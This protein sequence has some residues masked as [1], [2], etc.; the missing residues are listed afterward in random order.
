MR[1]RLIHFLAIILVLS[2]LPFSAFAS[3]TQA[4]F[5]NWTLTNMS[6]SSTDEGEIVSVNADAAS[7]K[8]AYNGSTSAN[9]V[10][11]SFM[12][13][14]RRDTGIP[15]GNVGFEYGN[16]FFEYNAY[17]GY[18]R[19]R[20]LNDANTDLY[21]ES[22]VLNDGWNTFYVSFASGKLIMRINDTVIADA[23]RAIP[24]ST[25]YQISG[26]NT[27]NV[28]IRDL[29]LRTNASQEDAGFES[30]KLTDIT[31]Q[32][33][34]EVTVAVTNAGAAS[35]KMTYDGE[36][37]A[38][39]VSFS[40]QYDGLKN[41]TIPDGNLGFE[42]GSYFFE[43]YAYGGYGR[44][45]D[46]NDAN[47]DLYRANVTLNEGWNSFYVSVADGKMLMKINDTV[48]ADTAAALPDTSFYQI[49]GYN[50][51]V[52]IRDLTLTGTLVEKVE[53][54]EQWDTSGWTLS[55]EDGFGVA[56][57]TTNT[58]RMK[59][60]GATTAKEI[61][62]DFRIDNGA[63]DPR[64][65]YVG[66]WFYSDSENRLFF[67]YNTAF[68]KAR[69]RLLGSNAHVLFD[70]EAGSLPL[71]NGWHTFKAEFD[72]NKAVMKIDGAVV[73]SSDNTYGETFEATT[74][75]IATYW[76]LASIRSIKLE[77]V[78]IDDTVERALDFE[79]ETESAAE[80]FTAENG[81]VSLENGALIYRLTG[82]S[83]ALM[84]PGIR[85]AD[86]D[87]YCAKLPQ[88]NSVFFHIKNSTSATQ[89]RVYFKTNLAPFY[90]ENRSVVVEI[91][92][93]SGYASYLANFSRAGSFS[94]YIRGLKFEP[95][96]AS[97]GTIE[98]ESIR[99]E[100]ED[101]YYDYAGELT[102]CT[103]AGDQITI[104]GVVE[105][106]FR[107]KTVSLYE[108]T[109][110]NYDSSLI[111]SEKI[112]EVTPDG[113]G[114][115][116]TLPLVH[117]GTS[118]L[119]SLFILAVDGVR[120]TNRFPVEYEGE[121]PYAFELPTL[122]VDVTDYGAKGDG[123]TDDT[124]AIQAAID[125]VTARG[126]GVV[127]L[128]GDL[129]TELGKRY[130]AT[131]IQLKSN[132]ELRIEEGAMV[133]Q[134]PYLEH[135]NYPDKGYGTKPMYG[136][137][138]DL[139]GVNWA[140]AGLTINYP[141]IW[142]YEEEN[143]KISGGG[144]VRSVDTGSQNVS[145]TRSETS[146][147]P[148][149]AGDGD[150]WTGCSG[151]LHV[152]PIGM[153]GCKN[154][155]VTNIHVRRS[156]CYQVKFRAC[157]NIYLGNLTL[158]DSACASGDGLSFSGPATHVMID[159]C[160]L[161]S[162][163]DGIVL[164]TTYNDLRGLAW[165]HS[166]PDI[167]N[168]IDDVTVRYSAVTSGHG[169]TFIP[170]GTD[171]LDISWMEIKNIVAHDCVFGNDLCSVGGWYDNPYLNNDLGNNDHTTVKNVRLYNNTYRGAAS[172]WPLQITNI[173][174]DCG[175]YSPSNF[176]HGDFEREYH[177]SFKPNSV[178]GLSNWSHESDNESSVIST[179]SLGENHFGYIY[180]NGKLYQGLH[181]AAGSYA[182]TAEAALFG[183]N[184]T[185]FVADAVSGAVLEEF[186]LAVKDYFDRYTM[187]FSLEQAT[188]VYVG[189]SLTGG[190]NALVYLDNAVINPAG[191]KLDD[192]TPDTTP[193]EPIYSLEEETPVNKALLN[194]AIA[195]AEALAEEDYTAESW[196]ALESALQRAKAVSADE[197][198]SQTQVDEAL[199]ALNAAMA[200]LEEKPVEPVDPIDPVEPIVPGDPIVPARPGAPVSNPGASG[201][202]F[203]DVSR[204]DW[205]YESVGYV[206]ENGLMNGI[207]ETSFAPNATTT[208]GMIVTI[209]YRLEGAPKISGKCPFVDVVS[210]TYYEDAI[211]WAAANGIVNGYGESFGPE[212]SIT[213]EQ[214]AA[215]IYRYAKYCGRSLS[216]N[217]DLSEYSDAGQVSS[218]AAAAME[219]SVSEGL[220]SG[221]SAT[222]LAPTGTAARAE[223]AAILMRFCKG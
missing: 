24:S 152:I 114:F 67:E 79:F 73:A 80:G 71:A 48:I 108:T 218:Y 66:V 94:G 169:L 134:S 36:L 60:L 26:Y 56:S 188:T 186:P 119:S 128:P 215:I 170:W 62:F 90:S 178:V 50:T 85:A 42:F 219:W 223:V 194:E 93:N 34:D 10:S 160:F 101:N 161:Y 4:G 84:T 120:L 116:F 157:E 106:A 137:D 201:M 171:A 199:S 131:C 207:T 38:N 159:R 33:Q 133:W 44:I 2:M 9:E 51:N 155:E 202:K 113:T 173:I 127:R 177:P 52:Q 7:F 28:K 43:Y 220:I 182:F 191:T 109:V 144:T 192:Y 175:I 146:N 221:R 46:L 22:V 184:G 17:G 55:V 15:D 23:K 30:W 99:F 124:G 154:I 105:E 11:F 89:M 104:T 45:R 151:R 65:G 92:P 126:G 211:T 163:D 200:A 61:E 27:A 190:R 29:V 172:V 115:S 145:G 20:D 102:S 208:R 195:N 196:T 100:R 6:V 53:G 181:L 39:A 138:L 164:A 87:Q 13:T 40:F 111:A 70:G 103:Y 166:T 216:A 49:S 5:E 148:M 98:I 3:E 132:V 121:N 21:R 153:F 210:G 122:T 176:L 158:K 77:N 206:F 118:R 179:S 187:E 1:N 54:F 140:H 12:T 81:E 35:F 174:S 205:F 78:I 74:C 185:L 213:R 69:L 83:S 97:S 136:H 130:L 209:L 165:W 63:I 183:G 75:T 117:N 197:N 16:Y 91:E 19:I 57:G 72:F 123:F 41:S 18:A 168:S 59:L 212:D 156:N 217:A 198:A 129:S 150:I 107:G 58:D 162:N 110:E 141:L 180:N 95:I 76:A 147:I 204:S 193:I 14:G 96:G 86:G 64:D 222:T 88:R 25:F 143:V 214:L 203:T 135:Y 68:Q 8:M 31:V 139:P 149:K 142:A 125:D 37:A 167:D 82:E 32:T 112:G 47:T 189:V